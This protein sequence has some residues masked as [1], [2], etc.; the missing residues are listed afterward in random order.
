MMSQVTLDDV[1]A[2][3]HGAPVVAGVAALRWGGRG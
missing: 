1:P 2:S 3:S